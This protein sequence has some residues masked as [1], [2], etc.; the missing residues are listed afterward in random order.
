MTRWH[1]A[2]ACTTT[3]AAFIV[4]CSALLDH[5]PNQ[6][7]V[8][9]DCASF[10]GNPYC[11]NHVCVASGLGPPGCFSGTPT[12]PAEFAN[13]CSTAKCEQFDNCGR[14]HL[15][16]PSDMEPDPIAPPVADAGPPPPDAP[17]PP[18][19]PDCVDPATR[20]TVVVGGSTAVQPFISIVAPLLAQ[21]TPPFQIAYQPSG[22]CVGVD[23]L[24]STDPTKH[25][26]KDIPGKQ[27]L[28]FNTDGTSVPCTFGSGTTLD[29]A[30]SDVFASSCNSSYATSDT[31]AEYLGP[32]QPMTFV[33]PSASSEISISSEMAHIVFGRGNSDDSA[34]PWLDPTLYF[35]RNSGSGTQQMI[36]RAINVDAKKWWGIDRGG[37]TKVRDQLEAVAPAKSDGAIGILSTDFA[38]P[39]RARLRILAYKGSGQICAY[40]PDSS[41]FTTDKINIRDGHYPIWGPVHFFAQVTNGVPSAAAA[42]LVTRF[43]LP[44]LD[45][46]LLDAIIKAGFVPPCAMKVQHT[47][48]MG[49]LSAFSPQ[50]YCGC[51]YDAS[52]NAGTP[53]PGCQVCNAPSDCPADK[54]ACNSGFCELR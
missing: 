46:Q 40:Y 47:T 52:V 23:G 37:S 43:T 10:E 34:A 22:S 45:K 44:R 12:T 8:D 14:L 1:H 41:Q 36:S 49:P 2:L 32:I 3:L 6:C 4:A 38:D 25:V 9:A 48:E 42:A 50:Y 21:G 7:K 51:Y 20:N 27:A 35:V 39:E 33:V 5:D 19:M 17:T 53:T 26:I 30:V 31:L 16:S 11:V 13:Q 15:C 24:F 54:P 18:P 28:L 29:V